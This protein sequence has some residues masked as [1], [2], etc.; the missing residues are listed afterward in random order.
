MD[1]R[2][3]DDLNPGDR[4]TSPGI[5]L[6]EAEIIDFALRYDPQ[7]FHLDAVAAAESPY[8]GLIASGFQSLALCFRLFIQSG[9]LAESSMGSPGIDELRWLAPVRP[10]DT[11]HTEVDVLE[12]RPSSTRPDRG[13]ARFKYTAVNQRGETVL[14]FI[15]AHL[16]RR[17]PAG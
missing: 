3:L 5:T 15:V 16:L 17:R 11:L 1:T 12:V 8:G 4:F 10:G 13:I 6:T 9:I 7:S 2:F 14:S